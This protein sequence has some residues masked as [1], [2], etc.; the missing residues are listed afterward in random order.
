MNVGELIVS[1]RLDRSELTNGMRQAVAGLKS[2]LNPATIAAGAVAAIGAATVGVAAK[3]M[4][5]ALQFEDAN[6]RM[7]AATGLPIEAMQAFELQAEKMFAAGRGSV[8]EI[9]GTMTQ[10]QQA[11]HGTAEETGALADKALVL[12][13]VFGYEVSESIRAVD[14]MVK[15]FGV[16]GS[17]A[18]DIITKTAQLAGD[19]A[20]DLLDTFNEY[21]VQFASM[22]FSAEEFAGI[23]VKGAQEGVFNLDKVGD[24]MKEFNI[25]AQDGSKLTAEGFA[26]IGLNAEEMGSAIAQGGELAQMAF[27]ATIAGLAGMEDPLKRDAAGVALF[28]TMWEDVRANVIT[29]MNDGKN[30]LG[31]F[32][33]ATDEAAGKMGSGLGPTLERIRNQLTL[34]MKHVGEKLLPT[35][36]SLADWVEANMPAIEKTINTTFTIGAKVIEGITLPIRNLIALLKGDFR[37]VLE[38]TLN[39]FG[40]SLESME[41][42]ASE[43]WSEI[44]LN[45]KAVWTDIKTWLSN[46]WNNILQQAQR[47]WSDIGNFINTITENITSSFQNLVDRALNW[48]RNLISN[49]IN[50]IKAEW[51][52]LKETVGDVAGLFADFI[53]FHSP[54][55]EGPGRD[56]DKWM[57]NLVKM[58]SKG[59]ED[60]R[61]LLQLASEQLLEAFKAPIVEINN[62]SQENRPLLQPFDGQLISAI[63]TPVADMMPSAPA[64]AAGGGGVYI[65]TLN[66]YG[67]T[68]GELWEQLER[69]LHRVGV[70]L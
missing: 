6:R 38:N 58:L 45:T 67:S 70:R 8:E 37:Q 21:S 64:V 46:T 3:G 9:Y 57:P 24:A 54:T 60:E 56:A 42:K 29:A 28:G 25:R 5:M 65:D 52:D 43:V 36:I 53:G 11:F 63:R 66:L 39:F 12:K 48:G 23:L 55:K 31:E 32:A 49:F 30:A 26:A 59:A 33:G 14:A 50:G 51:D 19:K 15:N 62:K 44:K 1:M 27:E 7:A 40:L 22:G 18:F 2:M 10:I 4:T 69:K 20:D 13:K 61:P 41:K 34:V 35:F 17:A 16:D 47:T 68:A